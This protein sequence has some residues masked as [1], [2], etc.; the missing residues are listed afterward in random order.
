MSLNNVFDYLAWNLQLVVRLQLLEIHRDDGWNA[1]NGSGWLDCR[2]LRSVWPKEGVHSSKLTWNLKITHWKRKFIFQMPTLG[3]H[4]NFREC[5]FDIR[6]WFRLCCPLF[7]RVF[8]TLSTLKLFFRVKK[9]VQPYLTLVL[10]IPCEVR[11]V[12]THLTHSETAEGSHWSI[13]VI[14]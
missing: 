2:F 10:Q 9:L 6:T 11:C 7:A 8:N 12:G 3:F 1:Q 14:D 5:I 13:I 4:V